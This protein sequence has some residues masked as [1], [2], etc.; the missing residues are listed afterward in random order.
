ML[1]RAAR[2]AAVLQMR[3]TEFLHHLF[4][5]AIPDSDTELAGRPA[6]ALLD[7]L[8]GAQRHSPHSYVPPATQRRA[9]VRGI[10]GVAAKRDRRW[11]AFECWQIC[12]MLH[13]LDKEAATKHQFTRIV[14]HTVW[15]EHTQLGQGTYEWEVVLSNPTLFTSR[16]HALLNADA[17]P[18]VLFAF[19]KAAAAHEGFFDGIKPRDTLT[20]LRA[21][22]PTSGLDD[23]A[24]VGSMHALPS[25]PD[26]FSE[27]A[28]ISPHHTAYRCDHQP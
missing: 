16:M 2:G 20:M 8:Y 25:E 11:T 13:K 18:G 3:D 26:M 6:L 14:S 10:L 7:L 12:R 21:I 24:Q 28:L 22:I 15:N 19:C 17:P 1:H 5:K 4:D 9:I 23:S 27:N